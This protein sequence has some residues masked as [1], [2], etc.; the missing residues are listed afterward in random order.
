MIKVAVIGPAKLEKG[1]I[2]T[3]INNIIKD[4][5][6]PEKSFVRYQS[7]KGGPIWFRATYSL[8]KLVFFPIFLMFSRVDLI[9]IHF[10]HGGSFSRTKYYSKIAKIFNKKVILHSHS[11]SF[12]L[13]YKSSSENNKESIRRIFDKNCDCL[14]VLGKT[15]EKFYRRKIKVDPKKINILH[16]S[17]SC[18]HTKRYNA[19]SKVVTMF[20]RLGERKGTYDILKIAKIFEQNGRDVLFKLYGDGDSEKVNEIIRSENLRN[21][22]V[23][24]WVSDDQKIV[25]MSEAVMNILPSYN[26]GLPMSI[27]ESM[28][29]GIPNVSTSVGSIEEVVE[30]GVNGFIVSPGD[31]QDLYNIIDCY[32]YKSGVEYKEEISY[33]AYKKI[34]KDFNICDY[35]KKLD[36]ILR[37]VEERYDKTD[38]SIRD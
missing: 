15:W 19:K 25:A 9:Y 1:G 21:V 7:W 22:S 3:V 18:S 4:V 30:H 26:E 11:S 10:A 17:V 33:A 5:K 14:I 29:L 38:I 2:A 28:A 12:D 8:L 32:I 23:E 13:F 35:G 34:K 31:I 20:G 16:N 37:R 36:I 27:L 24:H 6:I